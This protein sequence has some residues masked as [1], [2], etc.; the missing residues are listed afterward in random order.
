MLIVGAGQAGWQ[1]AEALRQEGYVGP[2]LLIGEEAFI[3]YNRPPLSKKWMLDRPDPASLA[4]RGPDAL[5]RR[6]ID[7]QL[8]TRVVAIDARERAVLLADG[9]RLPYA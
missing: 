6:Q 1:V 4:I 3:P 7:L 5:R 9:A 2:L 8:N